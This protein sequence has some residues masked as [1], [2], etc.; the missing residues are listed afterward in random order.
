M[1]NVTKSNF[2]EQSNDLLRRLPTAA[3]IAIDEEM[4]GITLTT[5]PPRGPPKDHT[6]AQRYSY[7]KA[8]P[9][10]YSIIQ[11][12]ICLFHQHPDYNGNQQQQ[13]KDNITT[14]VEHPPEFI[15][16][17]YNFYLFPP[18]DNKITREVVLN[19]SSVAFLNQHNMNFDVWSKQG[20]PFVT[21]DT[22]EELLWKFQQQKVADEEERKTKKRSNE[23]HNRRRVELRRAED[24]DFHARAMASV[25]EWLDSAHPHPPPP[26]PPAARR[27]GDR[28]NN[29]NDDDD[30][31]TNG[32]TAYEQHEGVM[33]YLPPCN[34]FL[35][36]A[37]Y[38]SISLEYPSL[39]LEHAGATHP[40]QIRILRLNP[41][42]Q[43]LRRE[44]I[45][46]E[47]WENLIINKIGM[48]RVFMA[49]SLACQGVDIPLDSITFA[50]SVQDINWNRSTTTSTSTTASP[51][52][53]IPIVV[54][55]GLHDL[56]FLMSHF[57]SHSLPS[58]WSDA[59][60]LL[61]DYF[62]IIYDTKL[63]A[64]DYALAIAGPQTDLAT[65]FLKVVRERDE[66]DR[67]I[68]LVV[69]DS[70]TTT[71]EMGNPIAAADNAEQMHEAA[72]DA[73]M[74]GAVYVGICHY[75]LNLLSMDDYL[76]QKAPSYAA[77]GEQSNT[78]DNAVGSLV[79]LLADDNDQDMKG[80]FGRNKL[81]LMQSL[82]AID[83]EAQEPNN[84]NN[85][86][87][88]AGTMEE[89]VFRLSGLDPSVTT[90][91]IINCLTNVVDRKLERINFEI[92]WIDD[93]TL[94][95]V[96]S[97][98]HMQ[99][100]W[101]LTGLFERHAATQEEQ[102]LLM[103]H[104]DL[105]L[106]HLQTRF[107]QQTILKWPE[108]LQQLDEQQ[109]QQQAAAGKGSETSSLESSSFGWIP[110]LLGRFV[111]SFWNCIW[112][113]NEETTGNNNVRKRDEDQSPAE[114][115]SSPPPKRRRII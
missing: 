99:P 27:P 63:M 20:I 106:H 8:V 16:R 19:P 6:P 115:A 30:D 66:E 77:S 114:S 39:I 45:V 80:A 28:E 83:L 96:A 104:G 72:Y 60:A 88:C 62:P 1:V 71:D 108:Y 100:P 68:E 65:L 52:R 7:L 26:H 44:R 90:R 55:N 38:E 23:Y 24:I 49:L 40:N 5:A 89:S 58:R 94:I 95:I 15:A 3:F 10:K 59:K 91:T 73:F 35:R 81:Y 113:T 47:Q 22:A 42:E 54:H 103:E 50:P 37:L 46:K 92:I 85:D 110:R 56:L 25:R 86:P 64:T 12:G 109:Q 112:T 36:R 78:N 43:L 75:I 79:H 102:D 2:L 57:H 87:L 70:T 76:E 61:H 29:D 93:R 11:L 4:T 97:R 84:D 13:S 9:E 107:P 18:S 105:I 41:Q 101:H 31:A 53:K 17:R 21:G 111:P 33:M 48:W 51:R 69:A 67:L 14:E 32:V 34:S 74:T 98:K 82:Y